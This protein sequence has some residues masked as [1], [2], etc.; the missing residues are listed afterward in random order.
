MKYREA[1]QYAVDK[2]TTAG[3][4]DAVIDARL[5]LEDTCHTDRNTLLLYPDREL[6]QAEIEQYEK[7]IQE[8]SSRIPL[9][10]I[11]GIQEFMGLQF[12][13]SNQ[14]LIP[15]QDTETLVEEVM[16]YLQDGMKILDMCTGSGCI[17]LSLLHYS[18]DCTGIGADLSQNALEV[19]RSNAARLGEKADFIC[20]DLFMQIEDKFDIIV[21]NPPY[22]QSSIIQNL[23]P[24][25]KD[26]EPIMAL[27]GDSDGL[28]FYQR[29]TKDAKTH[30][31]RGGMLFY[32]IGYDERDAVIQIMEQNGYRD[33]CSVKDLSGNDR[34][35]YGTLTE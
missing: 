26:N 4:S 34:V 28:L 20:S 3:I 30:L 33:I 14:V 13:V 10:H 32:E 15:R 6:S 11:T 5:L 1:Y 19:A 18:N 12:R 31:V 35:V 16:R 25:V 8:R 27:D 24:E 7:W 23:E 9:Q 2:L 21:S 17:L 22:I 29:I